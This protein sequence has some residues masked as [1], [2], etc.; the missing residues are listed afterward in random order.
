MQGSAA[1]LS[2]L[3]LIA[4]C[5]LSIAPTGCRRA[6]EPGEPMTR[7]TFVQ[8]IV[9]LRRAALEAESQA[10][11]EARKAEILRQAGVTD[12]AL[13]AY[14]RVHAGELEFMTALWDTIDARLNTFQEEPA[15]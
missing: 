13:L 8:V 12:S 7:D 11:F 6:V 10:A 15:R 3:I 2:R 9:D 14:T 1:V 4:A 5:A